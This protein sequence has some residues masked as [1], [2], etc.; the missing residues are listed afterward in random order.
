MS[1]RT[2]LFQ[3]H[4]QRFAKR[5]PRQKQFVDY[6]HASSFL[7]IDECAP[8]EN[9]ATIEHLAHN[10]RKDN[11]Q[12]TVVGYVHQKQHTAPTTADFVIFDKSQT[13]LWGRPD[14]MVLAI[15]E[16]QQFDI[17]IDLT[18]RPRLPLRYVALHAN[19]RCK[20]SGYLDDYN[21]SDFIIEISDKQQS[22]KQSSKCE[23]T[24]NE[25]RKILFAEIIRYLQAIRQSQP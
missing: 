22:N 25:Y 14:D 20:I 9:Y 7:I 11:K 6:A 21:L 8:T 4:A 19:A 10:L 12:V 2:R 18:Q 5:L 16:K 3:F 1:L 15:V 24:H 13:T 23:D 17:V